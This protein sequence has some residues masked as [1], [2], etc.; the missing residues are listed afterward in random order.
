[1]ISR[2][3]AYFDAQSSSLWRHGAEEFLRLLTGWIPGAAGIAIRAPLWR[4]LIKGEGYPAIESGV[5]IKGSQWITLGRNVFLDRRVY[6]HGGRAGLKI[7]DRTRV[8]YGAEINVYNFRSLEESLIEIGS[9]CV[10]GPGCVIMGQGGLKVGN[11]VIIGP[12]VLI[13]P[14]DHNYDEPGKLIR[15]QGLRL[16]GIKIDG[17]VWIGGGAIIL[18]GTTIGEGSIVAAGSVVNIAVP[19][20]CLVAG[21]PASIVKKF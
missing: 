13:L 14:V 19:P 5:I 12:K 1:M 11:D 3:K 2:L 18:A 7:G 16:A 9:D 21:N 6:L 15:E 4:L 17:N 20:R 10:I 8:M